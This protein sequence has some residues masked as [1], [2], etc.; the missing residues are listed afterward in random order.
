MVLLPLES[1]EFGVISIS[2][3]AQGLS[4]SYV[5]QRAFFSLIVS[6]PAAMGYP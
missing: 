6:L 3:K 2:R 5:R 4:L 1:L